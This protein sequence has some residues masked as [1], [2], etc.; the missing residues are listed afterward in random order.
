MTPQDTYALLWSRCSNCF[1]IE[2]LAETARS[3]MRFFYRDGRNDY[4]L[5]AVGTDEQMHRQAEALRPVLLERAEVRRLFS[6]EGG[7][8]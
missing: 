3:G 8:V 2:P 1:H 6:G 7:Q 4:L 5:L